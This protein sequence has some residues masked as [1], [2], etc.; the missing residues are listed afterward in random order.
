[1]SHNELPPLKFRCIFCDVM[2]PANY[3]AEECPDCYRE[4]II[5]A[6]TAQSMTDR[7]STPTRE[8]LQMEADRAKTLEY[9]LREKDLEIAKLRAALQLANQTSRKLWPRVTVA[10][11]VLRYD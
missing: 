11:E 6:K 5:K 7:E 10:H 8:W 9:I 3:L 4:K 2:M 1:M